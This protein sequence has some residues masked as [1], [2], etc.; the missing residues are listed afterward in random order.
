M[1]YN[2]IRKNVLSSNS[3]SVKIAQKHGLDYSQKLPQQD[4]ESN[5]EPHNWKSAILIT[6]P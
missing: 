5:P 6:R 2:T 1:C 4:W 3:D